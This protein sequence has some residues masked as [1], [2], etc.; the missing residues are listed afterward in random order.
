MKIKYFFLIFVCSIF[1]S[2]NEKQT[3]SNNNIINSK[4]FSN[5]LID[6]NEKKFDFTSENVQNFLKKNAELVGYEGFYNYGDGVWLQIHNIS[7]YRV[8]DSEWLKRNIPKISKYITVIELHNYENLLYLFPDSKRI[9]F[10][11]HESSIKELDLTTV[12][13]GCENLI[14][15]DY[16]LLNLDAISKLQNL[17]A[18]DFSCTSQE[19]R[20]VENENLKY[21]GIELNPEEDFDCEDVLKFPNLEELH[22]YGCSEIKNLRALKYLNL[23]MLQIFPEEK[24][25]MYKVELDELQNDLDQLFIYSIRE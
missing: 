11:N 8:T 4:G 13:S 22:I 7:N 20:Q 24:L 15:K 1:L 10:Y 21:I 18:I 19:F 23:K 12:P 3:V 17:K 14:C 16:K 2:C 6:I 5:N 25:N 9:D